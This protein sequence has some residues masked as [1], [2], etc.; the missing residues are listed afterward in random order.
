MESTVNGTIGEEGI[1]MEIRCVGSNSHLF[2]VDC[3]SFR[4]RGT[5]VDG[6]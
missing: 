4:I 5:D 2:L 1:L 3:L 6:S